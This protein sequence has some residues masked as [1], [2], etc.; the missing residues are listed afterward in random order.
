[1]LGLLLADMGGGKAAA[2]TTKGKTVVKEKI[3]EKIVH[4]SN[5]EQLDTEK[6]RIKEVAILFV[7][8][9]LITLLKDVIP[10]ISW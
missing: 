2:Q 5:D 9:K 4:V 10:L 1:M 6:N 3:V 7:Q 8:H